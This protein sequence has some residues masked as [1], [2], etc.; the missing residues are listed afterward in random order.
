M[1]SDFARS[2][3]AAFG[4]PFFHSRL[5][6]ETSSSALLFA[7]SFGSVGESAALAAAARGGG[8]PGGGGTFK[9]SV[10]D[11]RLG[12]GGA[13]GDSLAGGGG[14]R[15][16]FEVGDDELPAGFGGI[17]SPGGGATNVSR[18]L[19]GIASPGGGA[20]ADPLESPGGGASPADDGDLPTGE[21]SS[22]GTFIIKC[23]DETILDG[24]LSGAE[25]DFLP[26]LIS[27]KLARDLRFPCAPTIAT[28]L[29]GGGGGGGS[30]PLSM[31]GRGGGGGAAPCGVGGSFIGARTCL[32]RWRRE[33]GVPAG[34]GC[35]DV[36]GGGGGRPTGQVRTW[37]PRLGGEL[38]EAWGGP[39]GGGGGTPGSLGAI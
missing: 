5:A 28:D 38:E 16:S 34:R 9:D 4:V 25:L 14:G 31:R 10:D 35:A 8:G 18:G 33:R 7:S 3:L 30:S 1:R 37:R 26:R 21:V 12:S 6:F 24:R 32:D 36:G 20:T 17:A 19:F 2:A 27:S 13:F 29:P 39:G 22:S 15:I 23:F 11:N